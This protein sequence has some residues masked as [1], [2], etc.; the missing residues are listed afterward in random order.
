MGTMLCSLCF[1]FAIGLVTLTTPLATF[2]AETIQ[3]TVRGTVM[4]SSG[5]P[6]ESKSLQ[7]TSP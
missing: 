1:L 6:T 7:L 5:Y 2:A 3:R 4:A